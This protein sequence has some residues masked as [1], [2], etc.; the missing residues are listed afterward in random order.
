MLRISTKL[1]DIYKSSAIE[2]IIMK[3]SDSQDPTYISSLQLQKMK[4]II[5]RTFLLYVV[6][7]LFQSVL[8]SILTKIKLICDI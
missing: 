6:T 3:L 2:E 5:V 7:Y 4:L 8:K 1:N